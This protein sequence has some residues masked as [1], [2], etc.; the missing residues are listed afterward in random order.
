MDIFKIRKVEISIFILGLCIVAALNVM[1]VGYRFDLFTRGGNLGFWTLFTSR[2]CIS[3]YDPYIYTTISSW[4]INYVLTRHP[5]LSL[6]LYPLYLLNSW[7]MDATGYNC[8]IFIVATLYS[9]LSAYSFLFS[10][11]I[12]RKVV[13]ICVLDSLILSLFFFSMAHVAIAC[14]VPDHYAI[15]LFLI[16]LTAYLAGMYMKQQRHMPIWLTSLLFTITSGVTLTNG[17]KTWLAAWWTN[18]KRFWHIK[19]IVCTVVLPVIFLAGCIFV[20]NEYIQ[21][22]YQ[23]KLEKVI[24]KKLKTQP[25]FAKRYNEKQKWLAKRLSFADSENPILRYV[26]TKNDRWD[27]IVENLFGESFQLHQ[28]YLLADTN[29][30]RPVIVRYRAWWN[31][32]IEAAIVALL[33]AGCVAGRKHKFFRMMLSWFAVDMSMHILCGFALTEVYIMT[34]HWAL[35]VPIAIAYL[36]QKKKAW[37]RILMRSM[38]FAI[39]VWLALWNVPLLI[40]YIW[41]I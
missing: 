19:S 17:I 26:D 40:G 22:P 25:A 32:M 34:A 33:I 30:S 24:Q 23:Q 3:G 8:T 6:M 7:L 9:V 39:T 16:T 10:Y 13:G 31:Y 36:L 5:L 18:G 29:R 37:R 12:M 27:T 2:F 35:I 15:S 41:H 38:L 21:K 20:Q 4:K 14:F 28:D 1:M 11:R